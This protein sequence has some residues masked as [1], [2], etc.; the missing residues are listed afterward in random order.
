MAKSKAMLENEL[1]NRIL[2]VITRAL[3]EEFDTDVLEVSASEVVIPC[4][5]SENNEKYGK[6]KVSIPRGTRSE[7]GYTPY[8][9]Y[10]ANEEWKFTKAERENRAKAIEEKRARAEAEKERKRAARQTIKTMKKDVRE[11]LPN[12]A[13]ENHSSG[14]DETKKIVEEIQQTT[15]D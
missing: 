8:N 12:A 2:A 5:D 6:I 9:G 4:V 10:D 15:T 13:K 1:R 14:N 3:E 11:I 7:G